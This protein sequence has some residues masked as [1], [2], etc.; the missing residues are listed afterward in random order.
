MTSILLIDDNEDSCDLIHAY[1]S[2]DNYCVTVVH[3][4]L[5]ALAVLNENRFD[6]IITD[7][8]MPHKNGTF[9]SDLRNQPQC[10]PILAMSGVLKHPDFDLV[11]ATTLGVS[12]LLLKPF[13]DLTLAK[14][15][16]KA[17]N[18]PTPLRHAPPN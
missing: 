12:D 13:D 8:V 11:S 7:F 5:E 17:L 4:G 9:I 18:H 15:V 3:D 6:L 2:A 16:I 10:P 1:L 14:A